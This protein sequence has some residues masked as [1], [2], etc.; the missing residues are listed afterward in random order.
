MSFA[1][2]VVVAGYLCV[3]MTPE[4][5]SG[6]SAEEL[7]RPG[8]VIEVGNLDLSLGGAVANTGLA[9]ERFG[10]RVS[11]SALVGNDR[12]G[13]LTI[14]LMDGHGDTSGIRTTD[15]AS[16]A[17]SIVI[18]LPG[19][20]RT[21]LESPGSN[22]LY[23][24]R[25]VNFS[26]VEQAR[27]FHLGYPPLMDKLWMGD[28]EGLESILARA[29]STGAIT[30]LDTTLPDP[31]SPAGRADWPKILG[32]A[33]PHVDVFAPSLEELVFMLRRDR[34]AELAETKA[35]GE[36]LDAVPVRLVEEMADEV[37]SMG[38]GVLM[39]KAG[40]RGCFLRTGSAVLDGWGNVQIDIP[41]FAL[42][43]PIVTSTGAGDAAV[44]GLLAAL[45]AGEGPLRAGRLAMLAGCHSLSAP[46]PITGLRD[47][48]EML[49][50]V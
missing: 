45:L 30:S 33:L 42:D 32:R 34:H 8:A 1:Y 39:I 11:F 40:H 50:Q 29:A 10:L 17:Y 7:F 21:F 15:A 27:L 5:P 25:D 49:R 4:I 37:L 46:D 6:R 23:N 28:G 14:R 35:G 36:F 20:D 41:A 18:S 38:A 43:A 44:A 3:D 26:A 9:L 13:D 24:E 12:I 2:D 47:W 31:E 48:K 16:S 22:R 19:M